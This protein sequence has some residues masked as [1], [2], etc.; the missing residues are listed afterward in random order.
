M[1]GCFQGYLCRIFIIGIGFWGVSVRRSPKQNVGNAIPERLLYG[2]VLICSLKPTLINYAPVKFP[3]HAAK[4]EQ[5]PASS[6]RMPAVPLCGV[7][8]R[9]K[10]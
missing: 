8:H 5:F 2:R 10:C 4:L 6:A 7:L 9:V 3:K 1:A